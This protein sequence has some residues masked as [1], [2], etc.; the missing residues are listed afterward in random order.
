MAGAKDHVV[1][2][3]D[4]ALVAALG[5]RSIVL[6]GMMGAGKTS[7]G[8]RLAFRLGLSFVDADVEIETAAG[9]TIP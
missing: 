8:R 7:V 3:A 6:V 2:A 1:S 5:V 9:M 4:A